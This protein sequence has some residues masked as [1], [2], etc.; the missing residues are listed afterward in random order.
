MDKE[1]VVLVND[2]SPGDILIMSVAIRSLY[3][4]YPNKY[5]IDVRSPCNEIFN[6]NP[7]IQKIPISN[8]AKVNEA[9][10]KLKKN[11]NLPPILVE[12]TKYII[13]HYPLIHISGMSG[14]PFADGHRMFLAQKLGIEI[15][16]TG[17][18]PDIFFSN[19]ELALPRQ[20][21]GKY[22]LINAGIKNDYTLKYYPYYQEVVNL[23]KD[24][25]QVVQV[26]H[27]AHNHPLLDNVLDLRGK[28]NLRQLFLLS[29]YAEGA[30]CPVSLQMVIMASLSKPCV[31]VAGAREGVRWQLNPDH[32]FLYT[33]GA[34]KCAKYDGCWRS[35]IEECTFKSSEGNPMCMELIRP[36]DIAR[37]VELYYLG[38]V[39]KYEK[40]NP[41]ILNQKEGVNKM[42][43]VT[44]NAIVPE[45]TGDNTAVPNI[46]NA[47]NSNLNKDIIDVNKI[48][49]SESFPVGI[50]SP[51][52]TSSI[53]NILRILKKLNDSDTFLE[54]Y[55]W[56]LNK[57]KDTFMDTYHFMQWV[58]ANVR[59]KRILEIGTRT[60]ISIC[61]LL[62]AYTNYDS[63]EEIILCDL[64][65]DGLATPQG[66]LNALNYLN[67]PTD[68]VKFIVGSSLD[69]IPKFIGKQTFDYI[70]VDGNHDK[71]YA[72][73]D[74]INAVQLIEKGGYIVFDDITPDGCSLQDV[75][76]EFKTNNN[77]SFNFMENH[78]G[79]GLGVAKKI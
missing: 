67:I 44:L 5:M 62:S 77:A 8:N 18:K 28:T 74:L 43:K 76:D 27:T 71:D 47:D 73:K 52:A 36:E 39:L 75:W 65:N 32:R 19:E 10:E 66:V 11:D 26:G 48:T 72:R 16:R 57:R 54:A 4:A 37:A 70:L 31:V 25:I 17:M 53:F 13:S 35:K 64:F 40:E 30:I 42:D 6:N 50:N 58:G 69:E 14:L 60:G 63:L 9:I 38:G 79:K 34:I 15:P 2:L 1:K 22:W 3:K 23:L 20:I 68:K 59:P 21:K 56:H 45:N 29:K 51:Q 78:D 7:Y 33:N 46:L 55:H 41:V 49:V 12:D 24:K 61:Q